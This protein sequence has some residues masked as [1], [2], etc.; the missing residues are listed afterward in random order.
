M[1]KISIKDL[2]DFRRKTDK[3]KHSFAKNL[4]FEKERMDID[5]GG[6]YWISAVSAI[7]KSFEDGDMDIVADKKSEL[8]QKYDDASYNMVKDR[9]RRNIDVL[10]VYERLD[11]S[12]FKPSEAIKFI[13][14][15][16]YLLLL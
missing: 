14:K 16:N 5:G 13:K 3:G 1:K 11:L 8:I 10:N 9:W 7:K 12:I 15:G 2:V 6:D 4:Q